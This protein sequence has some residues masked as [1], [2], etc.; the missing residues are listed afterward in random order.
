MEFP[1]NSMA[2]VRPIQLASVS[3][4][5]F[6]ILDALFKFA[7]SALCCMASSSSMGEESFSDA[8]LIFHRSFQIFH[9]V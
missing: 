5:A 2:R 4:T 1:V 6:C 7:W 8:E 9:V 3:V